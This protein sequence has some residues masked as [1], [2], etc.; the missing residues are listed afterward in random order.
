MIYVIRRNVHFY[1]FINILISTEKHVKWLQC[2]FFCK[3]LYQ[4]NVLLSLNNMMRY[5]NIWIKMVF[6]HAHFFIK[7]ILG[8]PAI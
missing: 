6:W 1:H 5:Y 4:T 7:Q 2:D 3:D 8:L